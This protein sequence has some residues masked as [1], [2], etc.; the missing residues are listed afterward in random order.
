MAKPEVDDMI[1][2]SEPGMDRVATGKVVELLSSQFIYEVHKITEKG[3]EK[4]PVDKTSTR[5]CM[6][7]DSGESWKK[8]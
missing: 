2:H 7:N 1:E 6:Y 4:V 3:F 5:M 8:I